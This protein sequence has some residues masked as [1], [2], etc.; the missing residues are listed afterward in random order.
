MLKKFIGDRAFYNTLIAVTAP[1]VLQQLITSSVQLVDNVMV[2][3]LGDGALASV[4]VVNQLY[5]VIMLI[6]FGAMGGAGILTSQYNGSKDYNKLTQTFQFKII[7]GLFIALLAFVLFSF[8]GE[9]FIDLFADEQT[10]IQGGLDYLQIA[11][12]SAIPWAISIAISSTFRET[13]VTKPLLFISMIT[14]FS[15][16]GL[17]YILIF[18]NFGFPALGI[19]GA[20]IATLIARFIELGLTLVL[21]K[22][23]GIKF[24]F[25]LLKLFHIEK[26]VLPKIIKMAKPLMLNEFLWSM[27][28]TVFL[29]AYSTRG[30]LA[31][32]AMNISGTISQLVFVT[33]GAI[34]T[35]I[36]VM[37]GNTLGKNELAKAEDNA[38]KLIFFGITFAFFAGMLLFAASFFVM[39]LYPDQSVST[40]QIA[41]FCIR[42][43]SFFIAVYAFNVAVY[44]TLR[45]GGDTKSTL[46]MDSVYMWVVTVPMALVLAFFTSLPV[47]LMFLIIQGLDIPKA[48]FAINRYKK[49]YWVKNLAIHTPILEVV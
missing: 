27:G 31:L 33:F 14:I 41:I 34:G 4:G 2:A 5:F 45:S 32:D 40:L 29:F 37:V 46:L 9:F 43:N 11:K 17:N 48:I 24:H 7:I 21:L 12:Y 8:T 20:A 15:N 10:T 3:S 49:K 16:M 42:V 36:E 39:F 47:T 26:E 18:G 22:R 38:R 25:S 6:T 28:Q 23:S 30:D 13:G 19:S 35:G 44:F 1:L